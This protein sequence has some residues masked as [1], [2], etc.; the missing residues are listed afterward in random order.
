MVFIKDSEEEQIRNYHWIWHILQC[1]PAPWEKGHCG[2]GCDQ[3]TKAF[4]ERVTSSSLLEAL[5]HSAIK[6]SGSSGNS[7]YWSSS[8]SH[9]LHVLLEPCSGVW[10]RCVLT[11]FFVF[12]SCCQ[13]GLNEMC[14][15]TFLLREDR[16]IFFCSLVTSR[17]GKYLSREFI[18]LANC[19]GEKKTCLM[20]RASSPALCRS[21]FAC[22][23]A[24]C[25]RHLPE[26]PAG[27]AVGKLGCTQ[28][29][30]GKKET[31]LN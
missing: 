30:L 1:Y 16:S 26:P 3:G 24:A 14:H 22:S 15:F 4:R 29:R 25:S 28:D 20:C 9:N 13:T 2:W 12:W 31:C 23:Q 10:T 27:N 18:L 8:L 11:C 17:S 19:D 7:G 21:A 5:S 6:S